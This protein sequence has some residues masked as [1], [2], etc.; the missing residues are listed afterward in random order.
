MKLRRCTAQ[1]AMSFYKMQRRLSACHY[2]PFWRR[3]CG[4]GGAAYF[5]ARGEG[6]RCSAP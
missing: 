4:R 5:Y 6:G 2:P 1:S 3:A